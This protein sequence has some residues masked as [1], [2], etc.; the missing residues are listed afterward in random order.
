MRRLVAL[1]T[2]VAALAAWGCGGSAPSGDRA[3]PPPAQP[4]AA[5]ATAEKVAGH[6]PTPEQLAVRQELLAQIAAGT[7]HCS[8]TSAERARDRVARGL[9][10]TPGD[11][12]PAPT[13]PKG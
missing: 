8:C 4:A 1:L 13:L 11:A 12:Q 2:G 3:Q 7:Y 6:E 9:V 10:K 5:A